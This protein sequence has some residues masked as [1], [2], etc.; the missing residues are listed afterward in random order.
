MSRLT[1][2]DPTNK[3]HQAIVLAWVTSADQFGVGRLTAIREGFEMNDIQF[4]SHKVGVYLFEQ[5]QK[6]VIS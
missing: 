5:I 2:F 4:D 6:G 1:L 3:E